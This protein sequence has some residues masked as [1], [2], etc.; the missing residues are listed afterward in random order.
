LL[1]AHQLHLHL[2]NRLETLAEDCLHCLEN[3][4][5]SPLIA[6]SI[7]V[8]SRGMAHWLTYLH[9]R[10]SGVSMQV[11]FPFPQKSIQMLLR[12]LFPE[13]PD[14]A[15]DP[16]QRNALAFRILS[17]LPDWLKRRP[18]QPLV[19][20][21]DAQKPDARARRAWQLAQRMAGL[22][23]QLQ[24]YRPELLR[25]WEKEPESRDCWQAHAWSALK[26][27]LQD[28]LCLTDLLEKLETDRI[29]PK[30]VPTQELPSM[31]YWFSPGTLPPLYLKLL[32]GFS[33]HIPIHL[34]VVSP[35]PAYLGDLLS[36]KE[37]KRLAL[38]E[39]RFEFHTHPW[40]AQ[41]GKQSSELLDQL[42]DLD[43]YAEDANEYF[44]EPGRDCLLHRIQDVLFQ[45]T[46]VPPHEERPKAVSDGSV[47]VRICHT[48]AREVEVLQQYLLERFEQDPELKAEEV[49]VLAQ[50]IGLYAP[51]IHAVF[52]QE[53][54]ESNRI[55]YSVADVPMAQGNQLINCL[56]KLLQFLHGRF[57]ASR[58]LELL[59]DPCLSRRFPFKD[60][61]YQ[62]L[63]HWIQCS[64]I[65][66]GLD[67]DQRAELDGGHFSEFT[68]ASG[69]QRL[70]LS[71]AA[72]DDLP[73][74]KDSV[75]C[76]GPTGS[77]S[78]PF[79]RFL[80]W[81]GMLERYYRESRQE[82]SFVEWF[83]WS[84][85]WARDLLGEHDERYRELIEL[86][87][88]LES[89]KK[90]VRLGGHSELVGYD[91]FLA[92]WTQMMQ[93]DSRAGG[94]FSGGIT[95][96]SLKPLRNIPAKV[97]CILGMEEKAFP[98]KEPVTEFDLASYP[99]S[100]K[101]D[102]SVRDDDRQLFL[103]LLLSCRRWLYLSYPGIDPHSLE[104]KPPSLLLDEL[105][106]GLDAHF[107]FEKGARKAICQRERL[108]SYHASYFDAS[109]PKSYREDDL[110]AAQAALCPRE[111]EAVLEKR[112]ILPEL[113]RPQESVMLSRWVSLFKNPAQYFLQ[114]SL[115]ARLP[116]MEDP[117]KDEEPIF[118]DGLELYQLRQEAMQ[119]ST[120]E[121]PTAGTLP[122]GEM[123]KQSWSD[124]RS[125]LEQITLPLQALGWPRPSQ[126]FTIQH[127]LDATRLTE[128]ISIHGA[129]LLILPRPGRL[130]P[131]DRIEAWLLHLLSQAA[132]P[133]RVS[134]TVVCGTDMA[135]HFGKVPHAHEL[136]LSWEQAAMTAG[137]GFLPFYPK[138]SCAYAEGVL[139]GKK[140]APEILESVSAAFYQEPSAYQFAGEFHDPWINIWA[141][142]IEDP[143]GEDFCQW[144]DTLITP[145][146][147]HQVGGLP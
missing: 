31:L 115:G 110:L 125:E 48:T 81:L 64:G 130:R 107:V 84:L 52:G 45:A 100:E 85:L 105:L 68:W 53:K 98:R 67:A 93:D 65:R 60:Q 26:S 19:S 136:L 146:L 97:V 102:R 40:L 21:L 86:G 37:Q 117:L 33:R 73:A 1:P 15:E 51:Y 133:E 123:G 134:G 66:W 32:L 36:P 122:V 143:L 144:A 30:Q 70:L 120:D 108:Q 50:D 63:L 5:G 3:S 61:D 116:R 94:F 101:G 20:F 44:E 112:Q 12:L 11:D 118:L 72:G 27:T 17:H 121:A 137:S 62:T 38:E 4:P 132:S 10:R 34:F 113:V 141:S 106:D 43:I 47:E 9:S 79:N 145:M 140:E 89:A 82:R 42:T 147:H 99:P 142:R 114:G 55:P 80:S 88:S 91:A 14:P 16:F 129:G 128:R 46:E 56:D 78:E 92:C 59:D 87:Q 25:Q 103:D 54:Q 76:S 6:N 74:W 71:Y 124:T 139:T 13:W 23:D 104:E 138:A 69:I 126:E 131:I 95:F 119:R 127:A 77:Q 18:F 83:D 49:L 24:V 39:Q 57:E 28:S 111:L 90:S 96:C 22:F 135:L 29:E 7:T 41:W 75:N 8:Q 58:A 2:S 35:S 109:N